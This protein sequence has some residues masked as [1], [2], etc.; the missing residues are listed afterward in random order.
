MFTVGQ[1]IKINEELCPHDQRTE[2]RF[3]FGQLGYLPF[4]LEWQMEILETFEDSYHGKMARVK[5]TN[6]ELKSDVFV[7]LDDCLEAGPSKYK[8]DYEILGSTNP[9]MINIQLLLS[10]LSEIQ[11]KRKELKSQGYK[12]S[13]LNLKQN[14]AEIVKVRSEIE[15]LS[16]SPD[17]TTNIKVGRDVFSIKGFNPEKDMPKLLQMIRSKRA[18]AKKLSVS[19]KQILNTDLYYETIKGVMSKP[20]QIYESSL[21]LADHIL[22]QTKSPKTTDK[23]LGLEIELL[24]SSN[25]D[26]LRKAL[27][28]ERLHKYVDITSDGS[29]RVDQSGSMA[30][31]LRVLVKESELKD[32]LKRLCSVFKKH[33]CYTNRS[34]G[35]HVHLDMRDR[36]AVKSYSKL[37]NVQSLMLKT[38]RP[39]RINNRFCRP[40]TKNKVTKTELNT[41]RI[42]L[43]EDASDERYVTINANSYKKH[44]TIEIRLHEGTTK[45]NDLYYWTKFLID[46]VDSDINR[47][48]NETQ[49]LVGITNEEVIKHLE[50]RIQEFAC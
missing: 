29:I 4:M 30:L 21:G 35:F 23:Y 36:D 38:Q 2:E 8:I 19:K 5:V 22:D 9:N 33:D 27:I 7:R 26:E 40:V 46:V 42:K 15:K 11:A 18:Q 12:A 3:Q 43:A 45:F 13:D 28:K 37:F 10:K 34:C 31:E 1:M 49:G 17:I 32:V 39:A 24:S 44:N 50:D 41:G 47:E 48:I 6:E 14:W 25:N 16:A 20:N